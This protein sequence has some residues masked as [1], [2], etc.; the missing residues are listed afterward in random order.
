MKYSFISYGSSN[1]T[2]GAPADYDLFTRDGR[3]AV[4]KGEPLSP[5]IA[6]LLR[7]HSLFRLCADLSVQTDVYRNSKLFESKDYL[8]AELA[9]EETLHSLERFEGIDLRALQRH[10]PYT[11]R[12][13]LNVGRLSYLLGKHMNL[14]DLALEQIVLG[15][16]L[17]DIGKLAVPADLL[18]KPGRL[19][20]EEYVLIKTHPINGF[21]KLQEV[22]LP[23]EVTRIVQQ[24]H[25]RWNGQGYPLGLQGEKIHPYAQ[26]V[27]IADVFDALTSARSYRPAIPPYHALEIIIKLRDRDF[28]ANIVSCLLDAV[29][30]YPPNCL[31]HLNTG[32][33]GKVVSYDKHF[34]TRPRVSVNCQSSPDN[35]LLLDLQHDAEHFIQ[36]IE[37]TGER[38]LKILIVDDEQECA[39]ALADAIAP[40]G[41]Q[42][43][44]FCSSAQALKQYNVIWPDLVI[45]DVRMPEMDGLTLLKNIRDIDSTARVVLNTGY[46]DM[47]TVIE[48]INAGAYGFFLKP[49][50]I[51][52]VMN[53]LQKA[54]T[55]LDSLHSRQVIKEALL[56]ENIQLK[57][58][59]E[60]LTTAN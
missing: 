23:A 38:N 2:P 46:G 3:V 7:S 22:A 59:L 52:E 9:V 54:Q 51:P 18:K 19:L 53:L 8:S 11:F 41:H 55:D 10:D 35:P 47:I 31:I 17:H 15:A 36:V 37:Y 60:Q 12:H 40:A 48:A 30:L 14:P 28:S 21:L 44:V 43:R 27:G 6:G 42:C 1:I 33:L 34:P 5:A 29:T 45:T 16:L 32:E 4:T 20:P 13:S 25:E 58:Q 57:Q 26:I 24:H 39:N 56:D 50:E 49:I